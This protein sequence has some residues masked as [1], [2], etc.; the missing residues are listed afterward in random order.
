MLEKLGFD[1]FGFGTSIVSR[2]WKLQRTYNFQ[3][4]L[5][6]NMG[7]VLGHFISQ[8]CVGIRFGQ[9]AFSDTSKM[10]Y[11]HETRNYA[12][13][14]DID[15]VSLIFAPPTDQSVFNYFQAW[16]DACIDTMGYYHP[17]A[18]YARPVYV[19]MFGTEG[20]ETNRFKM[21][22]CFPRTLPVID[23]KYDSEDVTWLSVNLAIDRIE[24]G[25]ITSKISSLVRSGTTIFRA[26]GG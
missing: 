3:V 2:A 23:L 13:L 7:G 5:P 22:G 8:Y 25:S 15:N 21:I 12:G 4:F 26:A 9:Y 24:V 10:R 11:A 17:K 19:T 18:E 1:L 16:K 20:F 6:S 14:Q